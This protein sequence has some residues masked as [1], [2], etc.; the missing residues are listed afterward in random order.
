MAIGNALHKGSSIF[1]YDE[2]GRQ[3][4]TI[5]AGSGPHDG[6]TGYT[7]NT[8]NIRRGSSIFTY[9]EKGHQISVVSA[10]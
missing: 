8:V 2:K 1:V 10:R 9:N 3:L 4:F 7:S 6:L 5:S